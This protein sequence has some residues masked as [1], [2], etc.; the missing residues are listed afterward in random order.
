MHTSVFCGK[1]HMTI[2]MQSLSLR[3]RQWLCWHP[4]LLQYTTYLT[5]VPKLPCTW[6]CQR[7]LQLRFS[8]TV[9]KGYAV[10][11]CIHSTP[12]EITK[13]DADNIMTLD[14]RSCNGYEGHCCCAGSI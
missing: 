13:M 14:G 12:P 10:A 2:S 6:L 9:P 8:H 11:S 3:N 4:V 5:C 7:L 1:Y